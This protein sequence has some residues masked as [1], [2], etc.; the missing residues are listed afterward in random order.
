MIKPE[1]L[2]RIAVYVNEL[3]LLV[4]KAHHQELTDDMIPIIIE[5]LDDRL[6]HLIELDQ[7]K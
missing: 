4:S 3:A 5:G 2:E 6:K 1:T 7:P